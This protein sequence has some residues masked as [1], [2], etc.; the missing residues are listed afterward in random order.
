M[1][2][3]CPG[4]LAIWACCSNNRGRAI[5]AYRRA[6]DHGDAN[7]AFISRRCSKNTAI[8]SVPWRP[9]GTRVHMAMT[10][11]RARLCLPYWFLTEASGAEAADG[12]P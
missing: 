2:A 5:D 6:Y 9:T 11:W 8:R 4:P 10:T 1:C 3:A 12:P 7:G